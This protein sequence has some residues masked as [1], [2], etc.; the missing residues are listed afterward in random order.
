MIS[1][2]AWKPLKRPPKYEVHTQPRTRP[3]RI[4]QEIVEQRQFKNIRLIDEEVAE[5]PYRPVACKT[6]YRL[7][8]V[9]KNLR[10]SEPKQERLFDDYRYFLYLTNDWE[11]TPAEIVLSANDRCQQENILAQL[12]ALRAL[13]APVDNLLANEAYML[14]TA[15]A[16]NLKAWLAL[17][18]PE[19]TPSPT[20]ASPGN[21]KPPAAKRRL[22]GLEF[23]TFVNYFL[24]IPA[25]VI[26]TGRRIVVRLLAYNHWQPVFFGL[27][28]T[29]ARPCSC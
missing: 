6:T 15:L 8:I 21:A 26:K 27:C 14:M 3:A 25:Q 10:V 23:R 7:V 12:A 11:S 22:L 29:F 24:R 18:L 1:D 19:K 2:T 20:F 16:W 28:E 9:R 5:M 13:H 17:L 4:K